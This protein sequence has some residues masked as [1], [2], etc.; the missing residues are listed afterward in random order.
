MYIRVKYVVVKTC[1]IGGEEYQI[2]NRVKV[3]GLSM[4]LVGPGL[5][6][7]DSSNPKLSAKMRRLSVWL[8]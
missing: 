3:I 5:E 6:G 1:V 7:K 8:E 2:Y 4:N